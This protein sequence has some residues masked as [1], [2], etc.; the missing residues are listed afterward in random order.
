M[1]I[2]E[3]QL[4]R[5]VREEAK[6]LVESSAMSNQF[7]GEEL[8]SD[9]L[10][11]E[12]LAAVLQER[13]RRYPRLMRALDVGNAQYP[14]HLMD[15]ILDRLAEMKASGENIAGFFNSILTPGQIAEIK[16]G[17]RAQMR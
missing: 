6:R 11:V 5:I 8:N 14:G 10:F 16:A 17:I 7:T 1:R 12:T 4:R 2:T 3:S 9:P 13:G 15:Q